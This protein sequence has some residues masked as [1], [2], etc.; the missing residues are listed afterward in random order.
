MARYPNHRLLK[1][2]RSYTVEDVASRL[3]VHRNTVRQ[4]FKVGLAAI[5]RRRPVLIQGKVLAE[6]LKARRQQNRRPCGP[7]EIYCVRCRAPK[8]PAGGIADYQPMTPTVGNLVGICPTCECLIF[9]RV[10]VGRL[11]SNRGALHVQ[12]K[13]PLGHLDESTWLSVNSDFSKGDER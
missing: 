10:N 11:P 12:L 2:H 1:L 7:G 6:F 9:R 8:V 4:W 5:D 3:G 13:D